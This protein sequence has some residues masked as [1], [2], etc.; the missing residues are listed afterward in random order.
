MGEVLQI[1]AAVVLFGVTHTTFASYR[2]KAFMK[3]VLGARVATAT[4]RL[5]Y[6]LIAVIS[7]APALYLVLTLP[8][9]ELYRFPEPL[10]VVALSIQALAALAVIYSLYQLDLP[11]FVGLRQLIEPPIDYSID[12]TS[13]AHL[14]TD[15]LHGYV[16]HPLYASA[17]MV[18]YLVSPMTINRLALTV[19]FH[20]YF[21]IGSIFEECKLVR[22][23]GH[24]YREYQ[25]RVPR[26]LPRPRRGVA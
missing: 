4:Y 15:G 1:I 12:S 21:Y 19:C 5:I 14:V 23:F 24:A 3:R 20:F 9:R 26:L 18:L 13:T 17:L 2:V 16:R 7:I 11:F 6:N 25:R 22:E 8:D 10:N